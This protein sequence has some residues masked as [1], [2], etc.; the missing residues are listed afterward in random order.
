MDMRRRGALPSK[1]LSSK[2]SDYR[3]SRKIELFPKLL[4]Y[5]ALVSAADK[6]GVVDKK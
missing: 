6:L 4:V 2:I 3:R 1:I 5:I